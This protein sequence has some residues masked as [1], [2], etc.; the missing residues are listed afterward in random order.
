M[1]VS[2][3][4]QTV[5]AEVDGQGQQQVQVQE[6]LLPAT[7]KPEEGLEVWRIWAQRKNAELEKSDKNKL[8]PIGR[9]C[10]CTMFIIMLKLY[11]VNSLL[12]FHLSTQSLVCLCF[13]TPGSA[14][15]GGLGVMCSCWALHGSLFDDNR[16]PGN[17]RGVLWVWCSLLCFSVHT[18]SKFTQTTNTQSQRSTSIPS[19][20][21]LG[22][23]VET[24]MDPTCSAVLSSQY[25]FDNGRVD[26][27]FSDQYY[28]RFAHSLHQI[29]EPWRPSIHPLGKN[30]KMFIKPRRELQCVF[31][32]STSCFMNTFLSQIQ[33][34]VVNAQSYCVKIS[35]SILAQ[36]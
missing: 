36:R 17:G 16:G 14:F 7:L 21:V 23:N 25:L 27:V 19:L 6:L 35:A 18:K 20:L 9:K 34:A 28:T 32:L 26:D 8:A 5:V 2:V 13:R 1:F 3:Q 11:F 33:C 12:P 22:L 24:L 4:G 29:L 31:F 10:I 30:K 15:P